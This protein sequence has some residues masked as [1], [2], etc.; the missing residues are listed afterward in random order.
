MGLV[1]I[2][3]PTVNIKWMTTMSLIYKRCTHLVSSGFDLEI[4]DKDTMTSLQK[5]MKIIHFNQTK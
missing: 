3:L 2:L 1:F 5:V 4:G